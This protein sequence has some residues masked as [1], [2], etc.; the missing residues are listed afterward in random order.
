VK[1][2]EGPYGPARLKPEFDAC[3]AA[4]EAAGV[5]VASVIAAALAAYAR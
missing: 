5:P 2:S 1:V 4:A 3:A